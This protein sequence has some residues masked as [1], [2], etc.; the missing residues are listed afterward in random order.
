VPFFDVVERKLR[1]RK[2]IP[3]A[4]DAKNVE[5]GVVNLKAS[6]RCVRAGKVR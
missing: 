4:L 3:A 1:N 2:G 5:D 6:D